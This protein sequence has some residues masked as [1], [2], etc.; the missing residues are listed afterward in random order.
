MKEEYFWRFLLVF[1]Y[2]CVTVGILLFIAFFLGYSLD[3][4]MREINTLQRSLIICTAGLPGFFYTLI[5]WKKDIKKDE[6]IS[7]DRHKR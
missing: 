1:F 5:E 6:N 3:Y 7:C 2:G 4:Y